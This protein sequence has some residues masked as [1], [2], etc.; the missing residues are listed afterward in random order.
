MRENN[1]PE[2]EA[3][4]VKRGRGI[5][6]KPAVATAPKQPNAQLIPPLLT[7]AVAKARGPHGSSQV[8]TFFYKKNTAIH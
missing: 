7:L 2:A 1:R 6:L 4:K 3:N 8:R 5:A